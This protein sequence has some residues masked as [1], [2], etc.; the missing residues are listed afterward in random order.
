MEKADIHSHCAKCQNIVTL[1][2]E[3]GALSSRS[4]SKSIAVAWVWIAGWPFRLST[5]NQ[6][7]GLRSVIPYCLPPRT[8]KAK[9]RSSISLTTLATHL[10]YRAFHFC[11]SCEISLQLSE[12]TSGCI[13]AQAQAC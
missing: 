1:E 7:L 4:I 12:S 11:A 13:A 2:N 10:E 6:T 5:A 3:R 8:A 9:V